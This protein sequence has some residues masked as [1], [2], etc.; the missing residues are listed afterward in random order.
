[1]ALEMQIIAGEVAR[2]LNLSG[3]PDKY[4]AEMLGVNQSTVSRLR[5]EKIKKTAKYRKI[6]EENGL[7]LSPGQEV[8]ALELQALAVAANRQPELRQLISSLHHFVHKYM[9]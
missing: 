9:Q 3:R 5:T 4:F 7:L 6:L 1:M 8:M 2:A